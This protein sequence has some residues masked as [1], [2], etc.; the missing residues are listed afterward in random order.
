MNPNESELIDEELTAYLDGELSASN[1]ADLERRLVDDLPLRNRLASLRKAYDLL[2]DLPETPHNRNFTQSTIEMVVADLKQSAA[3]PIAPSVLTPTKI[4]WFEWPRILAPI[5]S[6]LAVG[7]TIGTLAAFSQIRSEL[8]QLSLIS[9]IPGLQDTSEIG[10]AT[11]IAKEKELIEYLSDRYIDRAIPHLPTSVWQ[12]RNWVRSLNQTQIAKLESAK[13]LLLKLP[14]DNRVRLEAVQSQIDARPDADTINQAIRVTGTVLDSLPST[15]RQ[16][17]DGQTAE[18]RARFLKEQLYLKAAM[19]YAADLNASDA[20]A[21][22]E[23]G[24]NQ[25]LPVLIANMP[26]LRRE[27]D[28]RT[29]LMSLYSN[30]PVEDGFRLDNQDELVTEL[31]NSLSPF[32]KRLLEGIDR[33][34]QLIVVSA[35]MVP[36]GINNER[37]LESYDRLRRDSR[38]EID[39]VDPKE[40]KRLLKE[41]SRRIGSGTRVRP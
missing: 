18:Q 28:V 41:R 25:L 16:D 1:A 35:W 4:N 2:D 34:D 17:L 38:E 32:P 14:V 31:T 20:T 40:A 6:M 24:K 27:T 37:L 3:N 7:T 10:V 12:R 15:K 39:L 21:L 5:L 19:F 11:D 13:E 33:T 29:A 26:F 8:S 23:W 22:E 9:N 30:R 36:E